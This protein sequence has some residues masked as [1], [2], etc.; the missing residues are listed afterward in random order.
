MKQYK[1]T[2]NTITHTTKTPT[3]LSKYPHVT[4][5]T[6]PHITKPIHTPTHKHT[7]VLQNKLEQ[8]QYKIHTK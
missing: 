8:P 6:H 1:N 3:H 7:D 4:K 2:L 5:P